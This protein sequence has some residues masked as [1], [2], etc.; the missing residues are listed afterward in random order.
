LTAAPRLLQHGGVAHNHIRLRRAAAADV[1]ALT[2]FE[3]LVFADDPNRIAR[4]QWQYLVER[5]TGEIVVAEG[6][7]APLL[8]VLVLGRRRGTSAARITSLGVHPVA[9]RRGVARLLLEYA[10]DYAHRHACVRL[11]L[12]VRRD[13]APAV[14]LYR[15]AGFAVIA[16][17]P[18]Y[19]GLGEDGLRME[20]QLAARSAG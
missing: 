20:V 1:P 15:A 19:Y 16:R 2:D 3:H 13:N 9:R 12:E 17:L 4:R 5:G 10:L 14:A 8:G 11:T 7:G 6:H 18:S